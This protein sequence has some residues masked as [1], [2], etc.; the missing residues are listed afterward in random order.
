MIWEKW[1]KWYLKVLNSEINWYTLERENVEQSNLEQ[2]V[3]QP[4]NNRESIFSWKN[5]RNLMSFKCT[6]WR[7]PQQFP[8]SM[9]V[10]WG[11]ET[12]NFEGDEIWNGMGRGAC[13]TW[14][15]SISQHSLNDVLFFP[16]GLFFY[17]Q[18]PMN[19]KKSGYS[20]IF[21]TVIHVDEKLI[22]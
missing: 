15:D 8:Y 2:G 4:E 11:F 6:G 19:G 17:Y 9:G 13:D 22:S 14:L 7:T 20:Q 21:K 3:Y 5:A 10:L 18:R 16:I 1:Y 12:P